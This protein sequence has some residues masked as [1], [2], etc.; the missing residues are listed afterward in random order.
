MEVRRN[1]GCKSL[2]ID[3]GQVQAV[4]HQT[5]DNRSWPNGPLAELA[6]ASLSKS[7]VSGFESR[8]GYVATPNTTD[9]FDRPLIEIFRKVADA[10]ADDPYGEC[11]LYINWAWW[12]RMVAT[13]EKSLDR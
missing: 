12:S 3:K 13:M 11:T 10:H 2:P 6:Y 5:D 1:E 7:G 9:P 8:V 4:A